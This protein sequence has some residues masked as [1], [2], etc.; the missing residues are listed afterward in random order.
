M[1]PYQ[2]SLFFVIVTGGNQREV[3]RKRAQQRKAKQAGKEKAKAHRADKGKQ[4]LTYVFPSSFG[5]NGLCNLQFT[6][7]IFICMCVNTIYL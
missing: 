4:K 5:L 6:T 1:W 3:D 2:N 7:I